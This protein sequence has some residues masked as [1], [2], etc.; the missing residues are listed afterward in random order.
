MAK[1]QPSQPKVRDAFTGTDGWPGLECKD[2]SLTDDSQA[3]DCDVNIIVA[4]FMKTGVLPGVDVERVYGDFSTV[5]QY[6]EAMN[7]AIKAQEQFDGLEAHVRKRFSNDPSEFLAFVNDPKNGEEMVKL[8]LAI[9]R[10]VAPHEKS[11]EAPSQQNKN[12]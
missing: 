4:R 1:E 11:A 8:G 7:I 10:E 3:K 2:K 9:K 5:P 6:Q 12:G